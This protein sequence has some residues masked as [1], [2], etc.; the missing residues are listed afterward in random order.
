MDKWQPSKLG[1]LNACRKA[2]VVETSLC[3]QKSRGSCPIRCF[4]L[5]CGSDHTYLSP[6]VTAIVR[7]RT[8]SWGCVDQTARVKP[9]I[10]TPVPIALARNEAFKVS[11]LDFRALLRCHFGL[12]FKIQEPLPEA[13]HLV[14]ILSLWDAKPFQS[15][16]WIFADVAVRPRYKFP[17]VCSGQPQLRNR[18]IGRIGHRRPHRSCFQTVGTVSLFLRHY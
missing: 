3:T 8:A 16:P 10:H 7:K 2:P 17:R 5:S 11:G 4:I 1:N 14:Q 9:S 13:S 12:S 15:L 6:R 18:R